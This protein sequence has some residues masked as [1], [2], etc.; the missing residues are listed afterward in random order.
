MQV[1]SVGSRTTQVSDLVEWILV[2]FME[3][4]NTGEKQGKDIM[5]LLLGEFHLKCLKII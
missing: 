3:T 1:E 5:C 4:G 2:P